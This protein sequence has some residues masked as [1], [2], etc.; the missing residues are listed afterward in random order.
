M[1]PFDGSSFR[2]CI[3]KVLFKSLKSLEQGYDEVKVPEF[4]I[5]SKHFRKS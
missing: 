1:V 2:D 4:L 5:D 3:E